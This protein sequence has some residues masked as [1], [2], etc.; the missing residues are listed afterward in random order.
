MKVEQFLPMPFRTVVLQT[1]GNTAVSQV[2][3]GQEVIFKTKW[4]IHNPTILLGMKV[5]KMVLY[6]TSKVPN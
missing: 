6:V 1:E 4:R 5:K 3:S 2:D